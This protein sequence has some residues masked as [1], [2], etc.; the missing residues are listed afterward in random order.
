MTE[1]Y[2]YH[3]LSTGICDAADWDAY[4][5]VYQDIVRS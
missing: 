5:N 3:F 1:A 4:R 2:T